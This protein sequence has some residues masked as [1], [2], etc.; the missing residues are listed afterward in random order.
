[1][2]DLLVEVNNVE[3]GLHH[4]HVLIPELVLEEEETPPLSV[5]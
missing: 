5:V 3:V 1:V 2:N 4:I